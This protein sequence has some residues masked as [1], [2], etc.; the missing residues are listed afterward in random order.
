ML[1]AYVLFIFLNYFCLGLRK[2]IKKIVEVYLPNITML[3]TSLAT[4]PRV[5]AAYRILRQ[6]Q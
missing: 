3:I 2:F 4:E 5:E 6:Y 1:A